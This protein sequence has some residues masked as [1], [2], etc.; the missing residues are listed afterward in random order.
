MSGGVDPV[1]VGQIGIRPFLLI[2]LQAG[3][4]CFQR[5]FPAAAE[6]RPLFKSEAGLRMRFNH[7]L[8]HRR[9]PAAVDALVVKELNHR[10]FAVGRAVSRGIFILGQQGGILQHRL[11]GRAGLLL[12]LNLLQFLAC[13][14]ENFRVGDQVIGGDFADLR[15]LFRGEGRRRVS[16]RGHRRQ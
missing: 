11:G 13:L 4:R 1:M 5:A 3:F 9:Q 10:D 2:D 12:S 16:G 8:H 15:L 7:L 6:D 14:Q